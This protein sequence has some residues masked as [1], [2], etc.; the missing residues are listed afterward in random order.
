MNTNTLYDVVILT[1]KMGKTVD[2]MEHVRDAP[3]AKGATLHGIWYSDIGALGRVMVLRGFESGNDLIAARR[4]QLLDGTYYGT[5]GLI[6]DVEIST[7]AHFPFLPAIEHGDFGSVYEMRT[8]GIKRGTSLQATLAAWETAVPERTRLSRLTCAM[9]S[10]DGKAPRFLN[11]WPYA[12]LNERSETRAAAVKAGIW[13][14][15]GGPTHLT[16]MESHVYLPAS[17]SPL[18]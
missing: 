15:Q 8:Y 1:A 7:Y 18:K 10:L 6:D 3:A 9:Y 4:Q 2:I 17:F 14:P 11:I 16:T 13:P 5:E 12:S